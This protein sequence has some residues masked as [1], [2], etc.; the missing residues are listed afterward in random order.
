MN[1]ALVGIRR[2]D[3]P[4]VVEPDR[5]AAIAYALKEARP[6]DLVILAGKGHENYQVLKDKTIP[7]DD[8]AVAKDVLNG[9]GYHRASE[10]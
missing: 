4:H 8:R 3:T 5:T 2:T 10:P 1:D 9:Y 7:F 6:G